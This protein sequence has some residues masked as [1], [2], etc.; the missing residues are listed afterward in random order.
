MATGGVLVFIP[1]LIRNESLAARP[2][3]R[4]LFALDLESHEVTVVDVQTE[5]VVRRISVNKS[6]TKLQVSSDSKHL[7]CF[8][9]KIQQISLESN[10]LEN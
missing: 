5:T 10:S 8:G 7:I 3:G 2:D 6:V 1:N 4:F 9:K